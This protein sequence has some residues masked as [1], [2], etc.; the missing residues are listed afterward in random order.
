MLTLGLSSTEVAAVGLV[1]LAAGDAALAL[2]A[3]AGS[4]VAA[5]TLGPLLVGV[6]AADAAGADRVR[7]AVSSLEGVQEGRRLRRGRDP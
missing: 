1:A 5:A 6:L 3:L 2:G 4:L 7:N